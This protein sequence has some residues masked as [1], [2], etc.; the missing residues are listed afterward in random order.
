MAHFALICIDKPGSLG[1]RLATRAAHFEYARA[2]PGFIRLAGP[3][4]DEAGEMTGS[5]ILM[6]AEG[7]EAVRAFNAAD[8]YT[9]AGLFERVEIRPWKATFGTLP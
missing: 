2:H 8:P 7:I 5:L 4:L 6:E 9:L 1:L 3:F